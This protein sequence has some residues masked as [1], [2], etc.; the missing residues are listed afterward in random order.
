MWW[1]HYYA[2]GKRHREKV[3]RKSD[4]IKLCQSRKADASAGR[5][6]PK[7][8]KSKVVTVGELID[9]VLE[10]LANHKD[11]R[12]YKSKSGI[13]REGLGSRPAAE[14]TPQ[15]LER[16]LREHCKTAATANRYKAFVSLCYRE[17]VRNGKVNVNPARLGRQ[18]KEGG[19]RLRFLTR[20][21]YDRLHKVV[22]KRFPEHLAE[23]V[24]SCPHRDAPD[25]AIFLHLVASA[26]RSADD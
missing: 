9:D 19:G 25:R 13:A 6:L 11:V 4:A 16:W 23:F 15:D 26:S 14:V 3:G 7:L 12:N 17:G 18:R 24:V 22:A 5:K 2:A 20:D 21:E 10:F 1:I 8:R